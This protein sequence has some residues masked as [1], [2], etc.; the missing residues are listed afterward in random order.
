M[1]VLLECDECG[2]VSEPQQVPGLYCEM[3]DVLPDGW[4]LT[5]STGSVVL[6]H[7]DQCGDDRPA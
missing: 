3:F 6:V 7:C 1:A 4:A 5:R 2:K